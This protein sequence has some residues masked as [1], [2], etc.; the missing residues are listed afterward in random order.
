MTH[1]TPLTFDPYKFS[2]LEANG[3]RIYYKHLPWAPCIHIHLSF[4]TG[5]FHDP[6]GKE[7]LSHFLEHMIFDGSP[8][9]PDRKAVNEWRKTYTLNSWNAHTSHYNTSYHLRCLP[10]K[11]ESTL[12]TMKEQVFTPFLR[13]ED[14]EHERKV[15]TQEAWGRYHNEK[16][17]KYIQEFTAQIFPNHSLSRVS[18]PLGWPHTIGHISIEDIRTWHKENYHKEMLMVVLVGNISDDVIECTQ[19]I[20]ADIPHGKPKDPLRETIPLPHIT[21]ITKTADEIGLIKEQVEISI[22]AH[23]NK[24][25]FSPAFDGLFTSLIRDVLHEKLR[26]ENSL[27][28]GVSVD[29]SRTTDYISFGIDVKTSEEHIE[30]V[31]KII[32]T[33][34]HN[35][36]HTDIY[37]DRFAQIRTTSLEQMRAVEHESHDIIESA[38]SGLVRNGTIR[39][40]EDQINERESA[41]F[42]DIQKAGIY[43]TD[44]TYTVTEII[45]PSK[46]VT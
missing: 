28:Y 46:K 17:L 7:G 18:S 33:E 26:D 19:R 3:L 27:C 2:S 13:S 1:S 43:L 30:L 44:P 34:I 35:I 39:T 22:S 9:L 40:M 32:E 29:R 36:T 12:A 23:K 8:T 14:A 5:A 42:E 38:V 41:T 16:L 10:E 21:H 15:I 4:N 24:P 6:L 25:S 37:R 31:K 11:F 45:L 20:L